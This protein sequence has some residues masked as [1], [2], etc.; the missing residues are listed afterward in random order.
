MKFSEVRLKTSD[1]FG[2]PSD[3]IGYAHPKKPKTGFLYET[4]IQVPPSS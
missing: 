2:T 3:E 1:K 4:L